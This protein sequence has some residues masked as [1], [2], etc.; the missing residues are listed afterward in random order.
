PNRNY[1]DARS[2]DK[3]AYASY[4]GAMLARGILLPPSQNEVMFVSVAHGENDIDATL[5]AADESLACLDG[6]QRALA[7]QA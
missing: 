1:D 4:Y 6:A 7:Q 5:A 2:A 3:R